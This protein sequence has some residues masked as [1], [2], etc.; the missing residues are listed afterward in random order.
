MFVF[1]RKYD[2]ILSIGT[3]CF[4]AL[5]AKKYGLRK[6]SAPLDWVTGTD[7]D[8]VCRLIIDRFNGFLEKED[9]YPYIHGKSETFRS[10]KTGLI[11]VHD[12]M[13]NVAFDDAFNA[14]KEKYARRIERFFN[15]LRSKKNVLLIYMSSEK[16]LADGKAVIETASGVLNDATLC[17]ESGG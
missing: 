15:L 9:L 3:N 4:V 1:H 5:H 11:F 17:C 8:G 13:P 10:K 16:G 7:F 14:A 6:M 2:Y 12:F